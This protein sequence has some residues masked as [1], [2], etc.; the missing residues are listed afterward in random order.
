MTDFFKHMEIFSYELN[1]F[2][3]V[4]RTGGI[5]AKSS[6]VRVLEPKLFSGIRNAKEFDNFLWHME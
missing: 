5:T 6:R 4:I 1:L 3:R 2:K